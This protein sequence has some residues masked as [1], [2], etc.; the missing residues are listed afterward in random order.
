MPLDVLVCPF[1]IVEAAVVKVKSPAACD[2]F[3]VSAVLPRFCTFTIPPRVVKL[4]EE[5]AVTFIGAPTA[6]ISAELELR[7]MFFA[8]TAKVPTLNPPTVVRSA[9][10]DVVDLPSLPP[11]TISPPSQKNVIDAGTVKSPFVLI[12]EVELTPN[13]LLAVPVTETS[14]GDKAL[15]LTSISPVELALSS[16]VMMERPLITPV[17]VPILLDPPATVRRVDACTT[18]VESSLVITPPVE[19][20]VTF[21]VV[22]PP[23]K[24]PFATVIPF[25]VIETKPGDVTVPVVVTLPA[26]TSLNIVDFA[27]ELPSVIG[28]VPVF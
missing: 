14:I 12:V 3:K 28:A 1:N 2:E 4:S 21:G 11:S 7:V 13:D 24:L 16:G 8:C 9:I 19:V 25:A 23:I 17:S 10:L 26:E 15:L 6:P 20:K 5:D 18:P 27:L 22:A